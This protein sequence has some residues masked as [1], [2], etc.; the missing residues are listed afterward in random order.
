MSETAIIV[1]KTAPGLM[2]IYSHENT[3]KNRITVTGSVIMKVVSGRPF[4]V[5]IANL[6]DKQTHFQ[7]NI[8]FSIVGAE[9]HCAVAIGTDD[10]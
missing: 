7:K 4:I 3:D 1:N 5:L 8:L 6:E 9:A 10:D 2:I